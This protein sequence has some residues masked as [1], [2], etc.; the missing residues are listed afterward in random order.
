[1]A[2]ATAPRDESDWEGYR[3]VMARS[4]GGDE[5]LWRG[6]LAAVRDH[7]IVRVAAEGGRVVGG[8]TVLPAGQWFGG[9]VVPAAAVAGV[10]AAPEARGR[11]VAAALLRALAAAAREAGLLVSPLWPSR[12][13]VYRRWG[14][15]IAGLAH[16]HTIALPA[17]A[18][19]RGQGEPVL[20]PGPE[21]RPLQ[22]ALAEGWNGPLDRPEW[23][24]PWRYGQD[25]PVP[26]S[27]SDGSRGGG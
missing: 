26:A 27:A 14:W 4:Y 11:G 16:G 2:E 8:A 5:E 17:L 1:M 20:D 18:G 15:E 7:A 10:C 21:I 19:L 23:W 25:L 24:W 6:W 9:R 22:P 12:T 3:R 13:T